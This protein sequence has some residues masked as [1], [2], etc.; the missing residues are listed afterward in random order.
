MVNE[1]EFAYSQGTISS[2]YTAGAIANTPAVY[3]QLTNNTA[4]T[5]PYGRIPAISF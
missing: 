5:D 3:Q 4:Y 1:A 2:R